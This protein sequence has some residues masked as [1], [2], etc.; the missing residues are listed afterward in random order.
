M[1]WQRKIPFGYSI[2][3]GEIIRQ[4][5][6]EKAVQDIFSRYLLGASYSNHKKNWETN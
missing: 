5:E 4:T 2:Q 3:N 1:A 6:E